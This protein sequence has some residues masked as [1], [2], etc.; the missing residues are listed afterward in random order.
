MW[1]IA[2]DNFRRQALK[3]FL[4]ALALIIAIS[5]IVLVILIRNSVIEGFNRSILKQFR[6]TDL[7]ILSDQSTDIMSGQV[8]QSGAFVDQD[9]DN[10]LDKFSI[11]D[12]AAGV[13]NYDASRYD[14]QTMSLTTV[15]TDSGSKQFVQNITKLVSWAEPADFNH[16]YLAEG[17]KPKTDKDIV[18]GIELADKLDLQVGDSINFQLSQ[19]AAPIKLNI[20]GFLRLTDVDYSWQNSSNMVAMT[21]DG[22][23]QVTDKFSDSWSDLRL[24]I[25]DGESVETAQKFLEN[26]FVDYLIEDVRSADYQPDPIDGGPNFFTFLLIMYIVP[27]MLMIFIVIVT[28]VAVVTVQNTLSILLSQRSHEVALLRIVGA[29]RIQIFQDDYYR[30]FLDF[31]SDVNCWHYC[32][33]VNGLVSFIFAVSL[34][35]YQNSDSRPDFYQMG[36]YYSSLS[37]LLVSGLGVNFPSLA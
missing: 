1:L 24:S 23:R 25:A 8:T 7:V 33:N 12:R 27:G 2:F 36:D 29:S 19:T 18:V 17:Q 32:W 9:I 4:V 13:I 15:A 3:A 14:Y 31:D 26:L 20:A 37:Q 10:L 35:I 22:V 6:A 28:V 21:A 16:F 5:L 11:I 30:G 34:V